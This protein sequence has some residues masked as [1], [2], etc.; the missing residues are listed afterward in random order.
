MKIEEAVKSQS[1]RNEKQKLFINLYFTNS[2]L[3]KNLK[4]LLKSFGVTPQQFNILRIL[5]GQYP[6]YVQPGLIKERL[7]DANSDVTR[8]LYRLMDKKLVIRKP[9]TKDRRQIHINISK[10]GLELLEKIDPVVVGFEDNLTTMPEDKIKLINDGLDAF[11][12]D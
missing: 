6:K 12:N 11:R 10:T 8:L 5:R 4:E 3:L 1:F 7:I 2:L 9:G